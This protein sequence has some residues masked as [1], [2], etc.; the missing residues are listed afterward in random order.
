MDELPDGIRRVTLPLPTRPGHVHAYLL[1]GED[2][3]TIVDSGLGLPDAAE[4]WRAE[5]AGI[6]GPV[7]RIVITHFHPDHVGA[8]ADL[9]ALTG[10]PV[11]QGRVDYEQ[12]ALVWGGEDWSDVLV[13]WFRRHGVPPAATDELVEQGS[14]YRPFVRFQP[15]PDRLEPGDQL[16]GWDVVG[17]PGHAD[18]QLMLLRDGVLLAADH[19]L[20][21]I[22]PT[23]GLWPNSRPDPLGDYLGALEA[24]I[25]LGPTL[26]L[27]GHGDPLTNPVGRARE[28]LAHHRDRLAA[29]ASALGDEPRSGY[30]VSFPLFGDDLKPSARRF[31]VAETLSHL[32]R[33]VREGGARRDETVGGV[34]YTAAQ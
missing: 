23:V 1:P 28:L 6:E 14:G 3:W 16:D 13:E 24:A 7:A 25:E 5:L 12:C 11:S 34:A 17:A 2:G 9:A 21:R 20:D 31:A 33:L 27:P 32:E 22:S 10:A 29:T 19:L 18:G 15:D 4:R 30:E 8:A 26:A